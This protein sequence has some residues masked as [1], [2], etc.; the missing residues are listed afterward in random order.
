MEKA[1]RRGVYQVRILLYNESN[2]DI[3]DPEIA[4]R[5]S[6][7]AGTVVGGLGSVY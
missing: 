5:I 4:V 7:I 2:D 1:E 6:S 3:S